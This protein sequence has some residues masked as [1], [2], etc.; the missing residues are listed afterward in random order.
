MSGPSGAAAA[1]ATGRQRLP[2]Y[3]PRVF[4]RIYQGFFLLLFAVIGAAVALSY[5]DQVLSLIWL[6]PESR[7]ILWLWYFVSSLMALLMMVTVA[8]FAHKNG[9]GPETSADAGIVFSPGGDY[10]FAVIT[11]N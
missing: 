3:W 2:V 7:W 10:V 4:R 11:K 9:W 1:G 8:Y 6:K 5:Y